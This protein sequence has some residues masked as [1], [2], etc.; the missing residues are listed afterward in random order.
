MNGFRTLPPDWLWEMGG[1]MNESNFIAWHLRDRLEGPAKPLVSLTGSV[2]VLVFAHPPRANG[3]FN[4]PRR[5]LE[6]SDKTNT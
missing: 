2:S 6:V 1:V 5:L 3:N 4:A